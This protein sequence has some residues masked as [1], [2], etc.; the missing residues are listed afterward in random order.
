MRRLAMSFDLTPLAQRFLAFGRAPYS[1]CCAV[2]VACW[3]VGR[4]HVEEEVGKDAA[5]SLAL[6][7][8]F[9]SG[10]KGGGGKRTVAIIPTMTTVE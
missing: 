2:E 6:V 5:L 8:R 4:E 3:A 1:I 7:Y 10:D 9:V